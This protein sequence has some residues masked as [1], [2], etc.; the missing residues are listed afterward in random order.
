[1]SLETPRGQEMYRIERTWIVDPTDVSVL[2]P[3]PSRAIT[4]VT[5]YPFYFIGSAPQRFIV[6]AVVKISGDSIRKEASCHTKRKNCCTDRA[7]SFGLAAG[8]A[9]AQTKRRDHRDEAVPDHFGRWQHPGVR[10]PEGTREITVPQ[11]FTFTVN[12]KP[13]SVSIEAGMKGTATITTTTT[14][15][16]VYVTEVKRTVVQATGGSIL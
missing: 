12:G 16:P 5:C 7:V 3:T 1:M 10:G 6:R 13:M 14:V 4:L 8:A 2:D 9:S 11:D 15:H